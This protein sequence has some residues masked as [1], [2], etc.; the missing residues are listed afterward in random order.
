MSEESAPAPKFPDI[1]YFDE[2]HRVYKRDDKGRALGGPIW[3]EHWVKLIIVGETRVSWVTNR[4]AKIAKKRDPN[5]WWHAYS[6]Q[7]IEDQAWMR[8]HRSHLADVLTRC[9]S[10]AALRTIAGILEYDEATQRKKA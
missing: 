10:V 5:A 8:S 6:L 7:D 2:N 1:W 3:R 4:G 9:N